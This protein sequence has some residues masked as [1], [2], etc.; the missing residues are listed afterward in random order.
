MMEEIM[1]RNFM[2][3][4]SSVPGGICKPIHACYGPLEIVH[5]PDQDSF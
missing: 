5:D 1:P 4:P 3:G 2:L